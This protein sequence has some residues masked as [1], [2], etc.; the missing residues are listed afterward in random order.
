VKG[1]WAL[2]LFAVAVTAAC[3]SPEAARGRGQGRGADVGNVGQTVTMH[4]GS[5][6]YWRTPRFRPITGPPLDA[7]RQADRLSR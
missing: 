4:E 2:V 7:A 5:D 1:A 6:P 3:A